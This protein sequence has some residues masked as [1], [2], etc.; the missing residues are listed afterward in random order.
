MKNFCFKFL[1]FP[2]FIIFLLNIKQSRALV[3]Q[4]YFPS[5]NILSKK[6]IE[7]GKYAYQLIYFGQIKEGL[8]LAKLAVKLNKLDERLWLI[9][10]EAQIANK[11]YK[12]A[13]ISLNKA[14]NIDP[15]ISEIYFAKSSIYLEQS[16]LKKAEFALKAGLKINP[17][18]HQ[19]IFQLGNIFLMQKNYLSATEQFEKAVN[20][21]PD[22]WQAINNLGLAFFEKDM[23]KESISFFKKA[24]LIEE[25][26][27]PLLALAVCLTDKDKN[28]A[29]SFAKKALMKDPKYVDFKYRKKQLWGEKLQNKTEKLFQNEALKEDIKLAKTKIETPY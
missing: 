8:S 1:L 29:I 5:Q 6:S 18:N 20:I 24:I 14:Q 17:T 11:Q 15:T 28:S 26:A 7:I 10:S 21:K 4:Y 23:L 12:D 16:N 25:N 9:L 3:P 19:A 13:L 27:E 2:I 22:F